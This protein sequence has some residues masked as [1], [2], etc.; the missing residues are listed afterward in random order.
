VKKHILL[1]LAIC[2]LVVGNTKPAQ[3]APPSYLEATLGP[4]A[5]RIESRGFLGGCFNTHGK[6]MPYTWSLNT[7]KMTTA[8]IPVLAGAAVASA[9]NL[10]SQSRILEFPQSY[11]IA[12]ATTALGL[13]V[14]LYYHTPQAKFKRARNIFEE[15]SAHSCLSDT[16]R[17]VTSLKDD[18]AALAKNSWELLKTIQRKKAN[19]D[20]SIGSHS[21]AKIGLL[22]QAEDVVKGLCLLEDIIVSGDELIKTTEFKNLWEEINMVKKR[23]VRFLLQADSS[24]LRDELYDHGQRIHTQAAQ[25][26]LTHMRVNTVTN[27]SREAR[28]WAHFIAG[29]LW[30]G[31]LGAG[32]TLLDVA[33]LLIR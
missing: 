12:G 33:R 6:W 19:Y 1:F 27:V 16:I 11:C 25:A 5:K 8:V 17:N 32:R 29:H 23:I 26:A 30:N 20:A 15:S 22:N 4:D 10:G 28:G 31:T 3:E 18:E 7:G 14:Y 24:D 13:G 21:K 9:K 2:L